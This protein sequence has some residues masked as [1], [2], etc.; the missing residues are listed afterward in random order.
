MA[1]HL[2]LFL[3]PL[4]RYKI[5]EA[6]IFSMF[7]PVVGDLLIVDDLWSFFKFWPTYKKKKIKKNL[8]IKNVQLKV[9]KIYRTS[10]FGEP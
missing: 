7:G 9:T 10:K 3:Y 5:H 2:L 1:F 8:Y 6:P 4:Y